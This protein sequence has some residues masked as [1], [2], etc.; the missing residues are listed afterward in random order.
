MRVAGPDAVWRGRLANVCSAA[1]YRNG[2]RCLARRFIQ[3]CLSYYFRGPPTPVNPLELG[4]CLYILRPVIAD[5]LVFGTVARY[6]ESGGDFVMHQRPILHSPNNPW[7]PAAATSLWKI[8]VLRN[9]TRLRHA[10]QLASK[11]AE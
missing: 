1:V 8:T 6:N 9:L 5:I 11:R 10:M 3:R 4:E 7:P 2:K